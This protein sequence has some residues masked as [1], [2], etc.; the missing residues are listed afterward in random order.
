MENVTTKIYY[1][2]VVLKEVFRNCFAICRIY[3]VS[4]PDGAEQTFNLNSNDGYGNISSSRTN[5]SVALGE[6]N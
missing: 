2:T 1:T 6:V 4:K 3:N 5:I